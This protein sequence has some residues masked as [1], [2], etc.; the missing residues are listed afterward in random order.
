ML[1]KRLLP[2]LVTA[3]ALAGAAPAAAAPPPACPPGHGARPL[4]VKTLC[5]INRA[6]GEHGLNLLRFDRRL[7]RAARRHARDMVVRHYFSHASPAGL[8]SSD[9]IARTGWMH[10]RGHWAV[11]ENLAWRS[12]RATPRWVVRDWLRS[13]AHR[14]VLLEPAFRVIGIGIVPGTPFGGA[15][16]GATYTADFGS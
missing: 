13:P 9:R 5:L 15:A 10:G 3:A 16:G 11:G 8:S 14:H 7:R 4:T 6:R 12:S 2:L 1:P